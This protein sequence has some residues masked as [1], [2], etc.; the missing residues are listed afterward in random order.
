MLPE[1]A[2]WLLFYQHYDAGSSKDNTGHDNPK[3]AS[4]HLR[5]DALAPRLSY[6]WP[7][8]RVFGAN[9]ET[10][11]VVPI[12]S[13]NLDMS[14]VRPAP[15][16]PLDKGGNKT[17]PADMT[18]A[19]VILGW[20]SGAFHQMAGVEFHLKTGAWM[21]MIPSISVATTT[22]SRPATLSRGSRHPVSISAPSSGMASTR[23]TKPPSISRVTKPPS[24]SVP[25]TTSRR[26]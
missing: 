2:N 8:V 10:R 20:H 22:R 18:F 19:P 11:I 21:S 25:A 24:S 13:A 7:G 9:L 5:L 6:V 26:G 16:P 15:L 4:F 17:G 14:A 3:L 12:V 1:G 23:V